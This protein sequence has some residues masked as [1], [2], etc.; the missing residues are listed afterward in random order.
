MREVPGLYSKNGMRC[1]GCGLGRG[2]VDGEEGV[3]FVEGLEGA[4]FDEG[5]DFVGKIFLNEDHAGL[6][7]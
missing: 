7:G 6:L 2:G 1:T 5:E 3:E 4:L